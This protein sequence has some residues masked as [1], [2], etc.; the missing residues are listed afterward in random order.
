MLAT[1]EKLSVAVHASELIQRDV[2][3]LAIARAMEQVVPGL[4][5]EW[6]VSQEGVP[7]H[8]AN[9]DAWLLAGTPDGGFP[10]VCNG[11]ELHPVTL[12]GLASPPKS[13]GNGTSGLS[14]HAKLPLDA[15]VRAQSASL[16]E[17]VAEAAHARWGHATPWNS[18][19]EIV[20]QMARPVRGPHVPPRGLPILQLSKDLRSPE[21]PH[22]LGWI[23]YWS[24]ATAQ[25]LG[26]PSPTLDSEWLPRARRTHGG[27]WLLQLTDEPLNLDEPA[28]LATLLRA[29]ERFPEIGGRTPS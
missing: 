14:V 15:V 25:L 16:L 9:R 23:N 6:E 22:H 26:F 4:R 7:L 24:A 12:H 11:D 20:E 27:G 8:V 17:H 10:L 3:P 2:R 29:Y 13:S 19:V 5:L 1:A 28:H 18:L 21:V